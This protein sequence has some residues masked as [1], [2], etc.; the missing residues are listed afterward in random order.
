MENGR[1]LVPQEGHLCTAFGLQLEIDDTVTLLQIVNH[2]L[3]IKYT[4]QQGYRN[5]ASNGSDGRLKNERVQS[6]NTIRHYSRCEVGACQ[7]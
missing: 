3:L 2:P 5:R 1:K 4:S 7:P 6:I